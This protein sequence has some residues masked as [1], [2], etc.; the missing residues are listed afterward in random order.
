MKP[1]RIS[2]LESLVPKDLDINEKYYTKFSKFAR[3]MG[4]G[5]YRIDDIYS[6]NTRELF[7]M[8]VLHQEKIKFKSI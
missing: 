4:N 5:I 6:T 3:Y 7:L 2:Y 1:D 8:Y